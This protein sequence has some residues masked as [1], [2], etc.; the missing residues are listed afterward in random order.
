MQTQKTLTASNIRYLI[1]M[2]A[3]DRGD[4]GVR[5]VDI[6]AALRL[7]KPSVHNMMDTFT[8]LGFVSRTAYGSAHLT[9]A[10]QAAADQYARYYAAAAALLAQR[11]PDAAQME[12]A[13]CA[14]LAALSPDQLNQLL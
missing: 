13:V 2:R 5:S 14:L 8:Q 1:A 4:K 6:A 7:S 3:L 11:F 9:A 10:G 12:T